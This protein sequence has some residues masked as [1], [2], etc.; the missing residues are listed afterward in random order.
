MR[1]P[2]GLRH[3]AV[4]VLHLTLYLVNASTANVTVRTVPDSFSPPIV[5]ENTNL[6]R[7]VNLERSYPRETTNVVVKN[8][9]TQSQSQYYLQFPSDVVPKLSGLIVKDKKNTDAGS[10]KTELV[11]YESPRYGKSCTSSQLG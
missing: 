5:F 8:I 1:L 9:D 6:V 4:V 7:N 10:F 11:Q 2:L 3:C